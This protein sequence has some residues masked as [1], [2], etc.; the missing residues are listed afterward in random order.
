MPT[1]YSLDR[2]GLYREGQLYSLMHV[3]AELRSDGSILDDQ[4]FQQGISPQGLT[5]VLQS[6]FNNPQNPYGPTI[7]LALEIIR[8]ERFPDKPSRFQSMFACEDLDDVK[9][10]RGTSGSNRST[11]IYEVM[12]ETYHRG[13]MNLFNVQCNMHEFYQ[14]IV[15]YWSSMT[16]DTEGY[17]P[18]WE[19]VIPLPAQIGSRIA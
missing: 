9:H 19:I 15:K 8:K 2:R 17:T 10:F 7:E 6:P 11:P 14:R 3:D 18:F 5:Y 12:T 4:I 13:D 1:F 16:H